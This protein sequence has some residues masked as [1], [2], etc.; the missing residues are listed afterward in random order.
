MM[1]TIFFASLFV[2]TLACNWR[3]LRSVAENTVRRVN[4]WNGRTY[5][6]NGTYTDLPR[7]MVEKHVPQGESVCLIIKSENGDPASIERS[8]HIT[9]S[10]AMSPKPVEIR[11]RHDYEKTDASFLVINKYSDFKPAG[12]EKIAEG[13]GQALW[14]R[15]GRESGDSAGMGNNRGGP[16]N[17]FREA[18]G[19]VFVCALIAFAVRRSKPAPAPEHDFSRQP[20]LFSRLKTAWIPCVFFILAA[21]QAL[22]HTFNAPTGLGVYGGKAKLFF[23]SGGIPAGFF[24]NPAYSTMQPAYPPGLTLLT[25]LSYAV[26]NSCGE[27]LTQLIPVFAAAVA[28]W[29]LCHGARAVWA[30]LWILA[31][32]LDRQVLIMSAYYYAEPFVALCIVLGWSRISGNGS[33]WRGWLLLG[34]AGLFKNE[35]LVIACAVSAAWIC[36]KPG[37]RMGGG[38]GGKNPRVPLLK[39]CVCVIAPTLAWHIACRLAGATLYDYAP[40]WQPDRAKFATAFAHILKTAFA[41]PWRYGFAYPLAVAGLLWRCFVRRKSQGAS[42]RFASCFAPPLVAP[43]VAPLICLPAF[44]Y[45][46]SLSLSPDFDWHLGSSAARLLWAPSLLVLYESLTQS[47]RQ[48]VFDSHSH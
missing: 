34:A 46:Y 41:E 13:P 19:A 3:P 7:E 35:G 39:I 33:D 38:P 28:L 36:C 31:A 40:V 43:L 24:T 4:S 15:E 8:L 20:A 1:R 29:G 30:M 48:G 27:W 26:S 5:H 9:L 17:P 42:G 10:W 16:P 14:R 32:F 23:L 37:G 44:A 45:V 47:K 25:L 12:F 6:G 18:A 2:A 21:A 22:S 11:S